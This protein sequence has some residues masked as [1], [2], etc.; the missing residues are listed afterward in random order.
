MLKKTLLVTLLLALPAMALADTGVA[1]LPLGANGAPTIFSTSTSLISFIQS[2]LNWFF[3]IIIIVAVFYLLYVAFHYVIS[4]GN[5]DKVGVAGSAFGY[6]LLGLAV[7][8]I[9][10]GLIFAVCHLLSNTTCSFI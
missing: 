1:P 4:G 7:A 6:I 9:A 5:K 2:I 8:L 10:K 3:V